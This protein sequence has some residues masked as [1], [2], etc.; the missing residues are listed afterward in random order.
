MAVGSMLSSIVTVLV[1]LSSLPLGSVTVKVTVFAP[2]FEQS[3]VNGVADKV[4][5]QLSLLPLST[6]AATMVALPE[7]SS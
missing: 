1:Q 3:N 4:T 5:E 7:A 2:V 6:S